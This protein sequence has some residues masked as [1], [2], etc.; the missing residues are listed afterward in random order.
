MEGRKFL[1]PHLRLAGL[2]RSLDGYLRWVSRELLEAR[3]RICTLENIIAPM[4][5]QGF[6]SR[7]LLYGEDVVLAP[8]EELPQPIVRLQPR[9][10]RPRMSVIE[11]R[12]RVM[13][14]YADAVAPT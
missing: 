7:E 9:T 8:S 14:I 2:V 3:R 4:V 13:A 11:N 5:A 1:T 6:F 12:R 10:Q